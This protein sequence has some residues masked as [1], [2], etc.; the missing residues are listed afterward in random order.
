MSTEREEWLRQLNLRSVHAKKRSDAAIPFLPAA[1]FPDEVLYDTTVY[2]DLAQST[3]PPELDNRLRKRDPW[4]CTVVEAEL[5]YLCGRL[6]PSH[7]G[8]DATVRQI[9]TIVDRWPSNRVLNPD[10]AIWRDAAI[11]TG[12]LS[13]LQRATA[14]DRGRTMNDALIFLTALR[15]ECT[16]LSRNVRDFELLQQLVPEGRVL[17]YRRVV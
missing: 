14:E 13:R 4:H 9:N 5:V 6:D 16:V 17:F 1:E 3:F 12:V 15:N 8:T 2:A 11:L 7:P 10:R